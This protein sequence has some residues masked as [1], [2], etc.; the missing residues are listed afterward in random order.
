MSPLE[1]EGYSIPS[2]TFKIMSS[3]TA[4]RNIFMQIVPAYGYS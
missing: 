3:D 1:A 2:N 4:S